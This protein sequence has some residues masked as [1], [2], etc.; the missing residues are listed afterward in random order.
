MAEN[1]V[2]VFEDV[3]FSYNG[4]NVLEK[5]TFSIGA[6]DF[7]AIV[8]PNGGGK[9]TLLRLTL[10]FLKPRK[11]SINVLG[12]SPVEAR[13]R[14]GYVPQHF[15]YDERFPVTVMDVVLMGRLSGGWRGGPFRARK[16]P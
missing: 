12:K 9:T 8:G 16:K 4:R 13:P 7:I 14:V 6:G 10:G 2:V 3:S 5:V 1:E 15:A 11:G